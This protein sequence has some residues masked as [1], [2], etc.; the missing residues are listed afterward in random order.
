MVREAGR[1]TMWLHI[2]VIVVI[3]LTRLRESK[4]ERENEKVRVFE[5]IEK[6][7]KGNLE[8]RGFTIS[9]ELMKFLYHWIN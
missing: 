1:A 6:K 2:K 8:N 9:R 5:I 7:K 3:A 4:R